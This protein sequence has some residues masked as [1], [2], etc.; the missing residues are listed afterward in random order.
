MRRRLFSGRAVSATRAF[1]RLYSADES[2]RL[3]RT[4]IE[5]HGIAGIRLMKR[6]GAAAFAALRETWPLAKKLSIVCGAGNNAGD[7]YIVAGLARDRGLDVDLW[8]IGAA[9][10]LKG[11][12]ALARDWANERGITP[13]EL[14]DEGASL[15]L[16]GDVVVDALLGT[17]LAGEPR[18]EHARAIGAINASRRPVLAIDL[19]SGLSADTGRAYGAVVHADV[20]V[21]FIG[22]K[23]GLVTGDGPDAA[24]RLVFASLDVPDEVYETVRGIDALRWRDL[25]PK[26][27]TRKRNAFKNRFGHVLVVGGELGMGGAVAMCAE[28]AL[29]VGAG[30]VSVATRGE[31]V[32]A[33]LARLPEVMVRGIDDPA[34]LAD[35]LDRAS[36]VAVGPGIGRAAWARD[37]FAKV[38]ESGKP[39]VIDA[40]ALHV[41]ADAPRPLP[42]QT[43]LT[44]HPGEAAHLLGCSSADVERDRFAAALELAK[45]YSAAVVLKGVG[46]IVATP[47]GICGVCLDGN[48]AMATAGMGDV[49]T[50]VVA[51]LLAQGRSASDALRFAVCL[52][53]AAGDDAAALEGPHGMLAT[54]V[55][56]ALRRV[57]NTVVPL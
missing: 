3:D 52:H 51:G 14:T 21:T 36:V 31:H 8:Q 47:E 16:D 39:L 24:G 19:P 1:D 11:D 46:S 42:A 25:R 55:L 32:A 38:V 29:R 27:P 15:V 17:G 48:P 49:L 41:L 20:T 12:A 40:D 43:V 18:P 4:A 9:A 13:R 2:R 22:V 34:E 57:Q 44:P 45:R 54:D 6:A 26:L 37:S 53:A 28:A 23:R 10:R 7:G 33:V 30:L 5:D 35:L 56:A 50:G